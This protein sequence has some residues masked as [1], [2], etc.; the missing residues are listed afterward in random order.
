MSIIFSENKYPIAKNISWDDVVEKISKEYSNMTVLWNE[1]EIQPNQTNPNS[2]KLIC[3]NWA[4]SPPTFLLKND[5][6]PG[7]I[8]ETFKAVNKDCGVK[9]MH[10]YI[11]FGNDSITFGNHDDPVDVLLVQA[12]GTTSYICDDITYTLN[13]G[14]SLFLPKGFYHHPI[15]SGP[16][17]TL[18]FSWE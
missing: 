3:I 6:Y 2:K 17:V 4:T 12:K 16:R 15:I 8:G 13:P 9:V 11:S 7:T 18:S 5:Y 14:D 1:F 10:T